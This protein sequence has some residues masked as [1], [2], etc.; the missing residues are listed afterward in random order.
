LYDV[1]FVWTDNR[2][3]RLHGVSLHTA[4]DVRTAG[5]VTSH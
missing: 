2:F 4:D 1:D 3:D 5:R